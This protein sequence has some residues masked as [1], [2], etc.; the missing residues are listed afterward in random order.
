MSYVCISGTK[1]PT[2]RAEENS[3][4]LRIYSTPVEDPSSVHSTYITSLKASLTPESPVTSL[5]LYGHCTQVH[6]TYNRTHN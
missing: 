6:K 3:Q 4:W 1:A 5:C 2:H